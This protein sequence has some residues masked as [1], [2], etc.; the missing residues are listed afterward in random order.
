MSKSKRASPCVG[1]CFTFNNYTDEDIQSLDTLYPGYVVYMVYGKEVAPTTGTPHLQGYFQL[2]AKA[3]ITQI[4][5][6]Y[7]FTK[8]MAIIAS[9]GTAEQNRTYCT[10]G[11]DIKE[12]GTLLKKGSLDRFRLAINQCESWSEVLDLEGTC[13]HLNYARECWANR[14]PKPM[15]GVI[16]RDWQQQVFDELMKEPDD[17]TIIW[18][19]D[20]KGAKGKTFLAKYLM[21]N[22]GA[23]YCSPGKSSDIVYAYDNERIFIYDIPRSSDEQYLNF[24]L[25]EKVKDGIMFSGKYCPI[26]KMRKTN[27]HV[28]VFSNSICQE[29]IFSEDRIKLINLDMI[30]ERKLLPI[31]LTPRTQN[32]RRSEPEASDVVSDAA[33]AESERQLARSI[34]L[35]N[36]IGGAPL[37]EAAEPPSEV[38][39]G[40]CDEF[41]LRFD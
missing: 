6:A 7:P 30:Q 35:V 14:K 19:Y 29:G 22:H 11:G 23:F 40:I 20:S 17:R 15:E 3:R 2:K 33:V 25:L 9:N 8:K 21:C 31:T 38:R 5:T 26:T 4:H 24:G 18:V 41:D 16:L 32:E 36:D 1:Y 37:S 10:K 28:V 39:P 34:A 13:K 12:F 27:A